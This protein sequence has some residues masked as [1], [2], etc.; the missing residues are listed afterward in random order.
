MTKTLLVLAIALNLLSASFFLNQKP[1]SPFVVERIIDG[2]TLVLTTGQRIR[3][4][5]I[6]APELGFCGY[7][8]AKQQLEK[9][10]PIGT[11]LR[12]NGDYVDKDGRRVALIYFGDILINQQMLASG[13]AK[14]TSAA[15]TE[16]DRLKSAGQSARDQKLG[17]YSSLC[18]QSQNFDQPECTIKGN[19]GERENIYSFPGCGSYA[20]TILELDEGDQW[21]CSEAEAKEAGFTRAKNCPSL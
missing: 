10:L 3:L 5:N 6:D 1:D 7:E 15:S 8:Q 12:L 11:K 21:F 19:H 9:L 16:N 17:V 4:Q 14:F 18:R 20:N 13:W 2:D